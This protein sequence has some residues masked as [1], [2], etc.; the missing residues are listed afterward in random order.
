[1]VA[2]VGF[3]VFTYVLFKTRLEPRLFVTF[4]ILVFAASLRSP[5]VSRTNPQWQVL[6][7]AYGIRY[8]FFP[9]L[10]FVW[11]LL[12]CAQ[13]G[14]YRWVRRFAAAMLFLMLIGI[15]KDWEYP[16]FSDHNFTQYAKKFEQMPRGEAMMFPLYP[17][18][19]TM[20]LVKGS[21]NCEAFATGFIDQP[22]NGTMVSDKAT[23]VGWVTAPDPVE[24]LSVYLD[25]AYVE[26]LI[27]DIPRQDVD[28]KYPD[29]SVKNKGWQGTLDM[30]NGRNGAHTIEIRARL[31]N[32]CESVLGNRSVQVKPH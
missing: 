24:G 32:G 16:A 5:L 28:Q 15:A 23:L 1:M 26:K 4:S 12:W 22:V 11:S 27:P 14:Q 2:T 19:W 21:R 30:P 6:D 9:M 8:W 13:T 7:Q 29:S 3:A 20:Q 31:K 18:G 25:G 17:D 10:A